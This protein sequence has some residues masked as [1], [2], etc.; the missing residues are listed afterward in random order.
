MEHV[1]PYK[2]TD[3]LYLA[4]KLYESSPSHA[5]PGTYPDEG[6]VCIVTAVD[7]AATRLANDED[8][9]SLSVFAMQR[10]Y[11]AAFG[12]SVDS[13]GERPPLIRLN[14]DASTEEMLALFDKALA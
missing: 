7:R 8:P 4:R 5:Q 11:E 9:Y 1:E 3:T 12:V 6:E 10:L 14:A 2:I 13:R